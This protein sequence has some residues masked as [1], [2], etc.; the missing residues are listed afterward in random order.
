[1]GG[2]LVPVSADGSFEVDVPLPAVDTTVTIA[3]EAVDR[4]KNAGGASVEVVV[5]RT[6][7]QLTVDGPT[8]G[9]VLGESTVTVEGTVVEPHLE[10][11]TVDG[12][13]ATVTGQAWQATVGGLADGGH[14]FQVRAEDRAGNATALPWPVT[15]DLAAP[16]VV[17]TSP[18]GGAHARRPR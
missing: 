16:E 13:P 12:Q 5:D 8:K 1:M 10:A 14:V 15:I 17:I 4:A 6:A 9:A 11:I 18:S 7:P 3:A 2:Q